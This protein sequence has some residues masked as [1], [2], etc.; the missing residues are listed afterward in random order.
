[1]RDS[2]TT[3]AS[4]TTARPNFLVIGAAKSGT[5]ALWHN[6][7]QHPRIYMSPRKHTRYFSF[8][9]E[10]PRF[11]GPG[12][13]N[14]T[15][16]YS[17]SDIGAYQA[18]FDGVMNETAIGEA[19]HSYLYR[20]EAAG[21]IKEY[22]PN[23]KLIAILRNPAERAFSHYRQMVRDGREPIADFELALEE[24]AARLQEGWWPDFHY[25]QIGLYHDQLERYFDLFERDQIKVYLYEDM[26]TDPL[27]TVRDM[28][29]FLEVDENF[30]PEANVRY[31]A[32]GIPKNK[33]LHLSLQKLRRAKR[34]VKHIV[35]ERQFRSL[36]RV[37][38]ALHN[39]NLVNP[40]LS[41]EV[42]KRVTEQ[43]F[44][45]DTLNL[46]KLLRRDLS[47]WVG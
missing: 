3:V 2:Q 38:S 10:N 36:L 45:E 5:T 13:K 11:R 37:G 32:S 44:R 12:P 34:V 21:R 17:I 4:P 22:A 24:E 26:N 43:Y 9:H 1:L 28:Y 41:P 18:L 47:S 40:R 42:R 39:R 16:P 29:R 30:V 8:D 15:V 35:P 25:V 27:G 33:A 7:K 31:N 6:L 23:M 20:P 14:P 19:S 46:Q